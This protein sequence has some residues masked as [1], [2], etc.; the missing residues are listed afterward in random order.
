MSASADI[1]NFQKSIPLLVW[2]GAHLRR[3][4]IKFFSCKEGAFIKTEAL[5]QTIT[6]WLSQ[7]HV[8]D[9]LKELISYG[10][11]I[12]DWL[13]SCNTKWKWK[14]SNKISEITVAINL[15][16]PRIPGVPEVPRVSGVPK[17]LGPK[18]RSHFFTMPLNIPRFTFNNWDY[19][20]D[21]F[22]TN[23]IHDLP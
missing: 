6:V 4:L 1:A 7:A 9:L 3:A 8:C 22:H 17:V 2:G 14:C 18:P 16:C 20:T 19:S 11:N 13:L 12:P 21:T 5:F 10:W 23:D 15:L